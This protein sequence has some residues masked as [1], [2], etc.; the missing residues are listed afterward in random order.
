MHARIGTPQDIIGKIIGIDGVSLTKYYS[1]EL[2]VSL[3]EANANVANKLYQKALA[4]DVTAMMFWLRT[5]GKF[6]VEGE[7]SQNRETKQ[8]RFEHH[9]KHLVAA[10][11]KRREAEENAVEEAEIVDHD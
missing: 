6:K 2:E 1:N 10:L 5:R 9:G 8:Y 11:R 4:G 3:S 7:E